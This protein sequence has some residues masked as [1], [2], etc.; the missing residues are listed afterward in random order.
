MVKS[1]WLGCLVCRVVGSG[2]RSR[3]KLD[4][5]FCVELG[6]MSECVECEFG[7]CFIVVELVY[8]SDFGVGHLWYNLLVSEY[9]MS[10]RVCCK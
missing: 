2:F 10:L 8:T 6:N 9:V 7:S 3:L 4:C 5:G 1:F